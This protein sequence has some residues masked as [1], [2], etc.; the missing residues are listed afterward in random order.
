MSAKRTAILD[1]A[2]RLFA[3]N[4]YHQV[5]MDDIAKKA[6]VAKGTLYYHFTSKEDLYAAL[7]QEGIDNLLVSLKTESKGTDAVEDLRLFITRLA[8]FFNEKKEFFE[9]LRRDEGSLFSK[10]LKNCYERAC[11]IRDLLHALLARGIADG[12]LRRDLDIPT[13]AE[14]VMGMIKSSMNG[15]VEAERLSAE[16]YTVLMRGVAA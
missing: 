16:I 15:T 10:R 2:T 4:P 8:L 12:R 3:K 1:A 6:R 14:I 9:V 13:T 11:S 5:A 7:L